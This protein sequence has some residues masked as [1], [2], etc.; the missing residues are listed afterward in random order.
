MNKIDVAI[1][2]IFTISTDVNLDEIHYDV[3]YYV[4]HLI[5]R[6][7]RLSLTKNVF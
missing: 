4:K 3:K 2:V 1:T 7:I 6:K 5:V